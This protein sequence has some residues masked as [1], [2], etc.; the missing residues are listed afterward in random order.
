[1]VATRRC[2]AAFGFRGTSIADIAQESEC[3]KA[4]VLYHFGSKDEILRV[5]VTPLW[6]AMASLAVELRGIEDPLEA[7]RQAIEGMVSIGVK[8][9]SDLAVFYGEIPH[10]LGF[11]QFRHAKE[12]SDTIRDAM[13]ARVGGM[14]A[15]ITATVVIAGSA[16]ACHEYESA[17]EPELREALTRVMN[18][19]FR[20][21][22]IGGA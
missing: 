17:P 22:S 13:T 15:E 9:R 16:A 18:S 6:D 12:A 19:V 3:S 4:T 11:G 1:M 5:L 2:F 14:G 10:I 8:H 21:L 7:Q 20:P